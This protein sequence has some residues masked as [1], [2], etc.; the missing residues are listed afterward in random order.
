VKKLTLELWEKIVEAFYRKALRHLNMMGHATKDEVANYLGFYGVHDSLYWSEQNGEICGVSTAHPGVKNLDWQ[1]GEEN[2]IW[3]AHVVWAD[4]VEA[5]AEVLEQFLKTKQPV[6]RLYTW[7]KQQAVPLTLKKL[8][9]ILS[10]G[11]RRNNNSS[12]TS[13]ELSGVDAGYSEG[14]GG[15]GSAGVRV[16]VE[17]PAALQQAASRATGISSAAVAEH[18][19]PSL[20]ADCGDGGGLQCSESSR[21]ANIASAG[22]AC[23]PAGV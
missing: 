10:Y 21:G 2:G 11:R 9:R 6:K 15:D 1:W 3:T 12:T 18:C 16:G 17:V 4:N 23:L 8:E 7:R 5:H 19:S 20:P 13:S 22:P 14:A